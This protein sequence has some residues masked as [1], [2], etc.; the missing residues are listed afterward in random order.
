[1]SFL[2]SMIFF[3]DAAAAKSI[4]RGEK[5]CLDAHSFPSHSV[6]WNAYKIEI[7]NL[8]LHPIQ[9]QGLKLN[10]EMATP[11]ELPRTIE[12]FSK[13]ELVCLVNADA[14]RHTAITLFLDSL[15]HFVSVE[16]RSDR[17]ESKTVGDDLLSQTHSILET[18]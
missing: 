9:L 10:C 13:T 4:F 12:P 1:M 7:R 18:D 14:V 15:P 8:N 16:Q 2:A 3:N 5:L 17:I 6:G 11:E